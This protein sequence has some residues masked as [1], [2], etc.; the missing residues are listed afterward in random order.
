MEAGWLYG[1]ADGDMLSVEAISNPHDTSKS[2]TDS[3]C[4][5]QLW[6]WWRKKTCVRD[7]R[8][9]SFYVVCLLLLARSRDSAS[10]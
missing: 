6:R 8:L 10:E 9:G 7:G 5:R 1:A 3:E 4:R 2:L